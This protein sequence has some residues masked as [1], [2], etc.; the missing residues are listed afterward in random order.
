MARQLTKADCA[1]LYKQFKLNQQQ[2]DSFEAAYL[3]A[4]TF[5]GKPELLKIYS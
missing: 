3:R 4:S 2:I 1:T 5:I